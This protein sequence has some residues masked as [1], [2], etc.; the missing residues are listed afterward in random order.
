ML[1]VTAACSCTAAM[2]WKRHPL[3]TWFALV[4]PLELQ[5]STTTH[6]TNV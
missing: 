6:E 5:T 1:N 4:A 3:G 2:A